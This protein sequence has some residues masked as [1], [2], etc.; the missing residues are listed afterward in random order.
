MLH[1]TQSQRD[2]RGIPI[3]RVGVK[4]LRFTQSYCAALN[5]TLGIG[6]DLALFTWGESGFEFGA[7]RVPAL[8]L[9]AF[10]FTGL[11]STG[12][13]KTHHIPAWWD[14]SLPPSGRHRPRGSP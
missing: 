9:A 13:G 10:E 8:R 5:G 2:V 1:D 7:R 6:R 11:A 14:Y 4:N 3:D 12:H